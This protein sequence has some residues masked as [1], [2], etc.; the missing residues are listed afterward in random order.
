MPSHTGVGQ[1]GSGG[2]GTPPTPPTPVTTRLYALLTDG[3]DIPTAAEFL[4][5]GLTSTSNTITVLAYAGMKFLHFWSMHSSLTTIQQV[6]SAFNGRLGFHDTPVG[7]S[8]DQV[9]GYVYSSR[10]LR[11]P[12][13][14]RTWRLEP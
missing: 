11:F 14:E 6:H 5:G 12:V 10:A 9:A 3:P 1:G 7:L 8:I 4:A 2:G 13:G